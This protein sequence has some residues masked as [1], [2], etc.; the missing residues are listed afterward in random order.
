M[1]EKNLF[2]LILDG[3]NVLFLRQLPLESLDGIAHLLH[4]LF[5]EK[6]FLFLFIYLYYYCH[7]NDSKEVIVGFCFSFILSYVIQ[8]KNQVE[9]DDND[10]GES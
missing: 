3:N 6:A 2:W 7:F 4:L 9:L 10:Y 8:M 5:L 1:I